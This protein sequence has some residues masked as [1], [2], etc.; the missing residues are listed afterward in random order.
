MM[1]TK[2]STTSTEAHGFHG[3]RFYE[4]ERSLSKIVAEFLIEGF[5][6]SHPGIVVATPAVR[7]AIVLEL[8]GRSLD[9]VELQRSGQ[10]LL[11]DSNEQLAAF[12][13]DGQPD[14]ARF[15]AMMCQAIEHVCRARTACKVRI[16]GQMVDVLWRDGQQDAAI[17]LERLWNQLA[18]KQALSLL[19]GYAMGNFYKDSNFEDICGQHSHVVS[20]DGVA[21]IVTS[22]VAE[23]QEDGT[24]GVPGVA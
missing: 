2:K 5:A 1:Q 6:D 20:A 24:G 4:S 17:H 8:A 11:L 22:E 3:V 10:F 15:N 19:C 23:R 16:F 14:P 18:N 21:R 13:T 12:M 7:A 9:V